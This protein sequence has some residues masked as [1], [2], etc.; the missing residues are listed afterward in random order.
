M[1]ISDD[2]SFLLQGQTPIDMAVAAK[3]PAVVRKLRMAVEQQDTSKSNCL[4]RY[5]RN[6]V[7]WMN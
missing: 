5:Y 1:F 6:K 7:Y 4:S 2:Y 3:L